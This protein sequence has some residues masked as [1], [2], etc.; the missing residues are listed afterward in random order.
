MTATTTTTAPI[1]AT[2]TAARPRRPRGRGRRAWIYVGVTLLALYCLA[3]IY[4]MAVSAFRRPD[5][6]FSIALVPSPPSIGNFL[7]IFDPSQGFLLSLLN[8]L[9]IAVCTTAIALVVAVTAGYAMARLTFRGKPL[10]MFGIVATS[11]FPVVALIIPMIKLFSSIGWINT[12]QAMILPSLSFAL[13]LAIFNLT[14]FFRQLPGD[15]EQAA[16]VDGCT[17]G[18]AFRRVI[19]PLAAPGIFTTAII[20]FVISWNEF[21]IPLSLTNKAQV[22]PAT[23]VIARFYGGNDFVNPFGSQ[24]AAAVIVTIPLIVLVLV[25]QRRIVSGLASGA[26]K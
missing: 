10:F 9:I 2:A 13:P 12:Y 17:R 20:T 16:M 8:S 21:L 15:L 24:M 19:L 26:L 14:T 22:Q 25:F 7:A 5:D 4:W 18:Q 11:M 23:V 6:I 3:P 1:A